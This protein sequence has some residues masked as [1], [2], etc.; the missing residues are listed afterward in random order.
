MSILS[1]LADIQHELK[2]P[3]GQYNAFG[4]YKYRSCEDILEALKAVLAQHE[5]FVTLSDE[6]V[7]IGE[8]YYIKSTVTIC[9][10]ET[11]EKYQNTALAREDADKKGMDG[12]QITGAASSYAR[13]YALNGLFAIDDTKDADALL[14][15]KS[16]TQ[17]PK[18]PAKSTSEAIKCKTCGSV[19]KDTEKG[20]KVTPAAKVASSLDGMCPECWRKAHGKK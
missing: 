4:K 17:P 7:L 6:I 5:C 3:K 10:A 11:G 20:G 18:T 16:P 8:R 14:G 12:S 1:K 9:D 2:A 19:I 15:E 13:K